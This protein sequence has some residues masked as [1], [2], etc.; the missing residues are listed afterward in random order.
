MRMSPDQLG[1]IERLKGLPPGSLTGPAHPPAIAALPNDASLS[2]VR[3]AIEQGKILESEGGLSQA[4]NY[5]NDRFPGQIREQYESMRP[6]FMGRHGLSP[7]G[8]EDADANMRMLERLFPEM[9]PA[10]VSR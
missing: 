6:G 3:A 1:M 5:L 7:W 10:A 8:R 4:R 2:Q 9:F